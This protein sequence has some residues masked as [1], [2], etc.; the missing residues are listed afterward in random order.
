MTLSQH[1]KAKDDAPFSISDA[2]ALSIRD[3][4]KYVGGISRDKIWKE[5]KAGN[6]PVRRIGRRVIIL[7]ADAD[8]WLATLP[9]YHG[10]AA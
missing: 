2:G 7:R 4:G 8:K 3:F 6:I 5:I 10:E 1:V 9:G